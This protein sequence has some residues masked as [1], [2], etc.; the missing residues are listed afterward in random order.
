[1]CDRLAPEGLLGRLAA[2]GWPVSRRTGANAVSYLQRPATET[3]RA[4]A[5]NRS[6]NAGCWPL[7]V[8]AASGSIPAFSLLPRVQ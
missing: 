3:A 4:P 6:D 8:N 5:C 2:G 7:S 1:M